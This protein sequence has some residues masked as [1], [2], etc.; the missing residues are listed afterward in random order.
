VTVREI[1]WSPDAL[2]TRLRVPLFVRRSVLALEDVAAVANA[3][4][5]N[6]AS[7]FESQ[8][9]VT[10]VPPVELAAG[11]WERLREGRRCYNVAGELRDATLVVE[12]RTA[13]RFVATAFGEEGAEDSL[14]PFESR[15]LERCIAQL[16]GSLRALCG[17]ARVC[18]EA[19]NGSPS[20][21]FELRLGPPADATLGIALGALQQVGERTFLHAEVLEECPLEC[22][23][24]LG[25]GNVDIFT[26]AGLTIGDI[27]PLETKV[28]AF[29]TLN[30]GAETIAAGEGGI[31][32]DRTAFK[33][34]HTT[35][36]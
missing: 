30:L 8:V 23:V 16:S 26:F 29:A 25:A 21:Y 10:I 15:V 36:A 31:L 7:C 3:M 35:F 5:A 32:G 19:R 17:G 14:S 6:L 18:A 2:D 1:A 28:G 11:D 13:R 22:W 24:R 4:A 27:V 20:V 9:A 33:V 34:H 12:E